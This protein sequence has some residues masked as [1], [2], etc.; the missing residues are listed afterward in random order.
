M[1]P[2]VLRAARW[3]RFSVVPGIF[4]AKRRVLL[5]PPFPR[6]SLARAQDEQDEQ[7]GLLFHCPDGPP[8]QRTARAGLPT[9][10]GA[11]AHPEQSGTP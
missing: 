5:R 9:K 11:Q 8:R 6:L 1:L 10:R 4:I 7:E 3:I 2:R